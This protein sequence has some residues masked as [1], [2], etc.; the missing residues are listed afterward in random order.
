MRKS[1]R[2]TLNSCQEKHSMSYKK[3]QFLIMCC[4]INSGLH[5]QNIII[6]EVMTY[7]TEILSP[8]T[9]N[10]G[11]WIEIFN[12]TDDTISLGGYY[13]SDELEEPDKWQFPEGI[14]ISSSE[15]KII[16]LNGDDSSSNNPDEI[17]ANFK[18]NSSGESVYIFSNALTL[19]DESPDWSIQQDLTIG[20]INGSLDWQYMDLPSPGAENLEDNAFPF[21]AKFPTIT[22]ESGLYDASFLWDFI[23]DNSADVIHYTLDF[24]DPD[25]SSPILDNSFLINENVTIKLKVYRENALA[26]P[27][28]IN[29]YIIDTSLDLDIISITADPNDLFGVEG[30]YEN[31]NSGIEKEVSVQ[32]FIAGENVINQNMGVKI[33]APDGRSQKSLRLYARSE[34]GNKTVEYQLFDDKDISSFKR[35]VLR[36]GGNDGA[37]IGE[38]YVRD[39]LGHNLY[40]ESDESNG[41]SSS[42]AVDVFINGEY[43]GIYNLRERQDEY[44]LK[45]NYGYDKDEVDFLEYDYAEPFHMKTIS[46]NWINWD[47]LKEFVTAEDLSVQSNYEIAENWIDID[48][49][50]D[51]QIFQI[52]IGNPDWCNNNIKFWRATNNGRWRWVMWDVEYGF[53]TFDYQPVGEPEFNFLHMAISWCGWGSSDYS[54]LFRNL[55]ENEDFKNKFITR[56]QDVLNTSFRFQNVSAKINNLTSVIEPDLDRQFN[57]WGS[58][59]NSW[60]NSLDDLYYYTEERP[61]HLLNNMSSTFDI[62][63]E[64][65]VLSIDISD[66]QAGEIKLNTIIL[67]EETVGSLNNTFPWEG[68]YYEEQL[69]QLEAIEY[70][71]YDFSHWEG[72]L[73][74]ENPIIELYLEENIS[75]TAVYDENPVNNP[76]YSALVINELLSSN[77]NGYTD[78]NGEYEDW[79]ELYNNSSSE[80]VISGVYLSD[81]PSN[82]LKFQI[83][84]VKPEIQI[85]PY[86]HVIFFADNQIFQGDYH[87]N[88]KLNSGGEQLFVSYINSNNEVVIIDQ[89][90]FDELDSDTSFGR[91]IDADDSWITFDIPT[92][93]AENEMFTNI[94]EPSFENKNLTLYPNPADGFLN[95]IITGN[96]VDNLSQIEIYSIDGKLMNTISQFSSQ[97]RI[98]VSNLNSGIYIVQF[99]DKNHE[100]IFSKKFIKR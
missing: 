38:S 47:L 43:W 46:G 28:L 93:D 1:I 60:Q 70:A 54:W 74:S 78:S 20:R 79:I 77:E 92:P 91:S 99:Y 84:L 19:I 100:F 59:F 7:N 56:T 75:L 32:M 97:N 25:D 45:S 6:N 22:A 4:A 81:N 12:P 69:I 35:L 14:T 39:I 62:P 82:L 37:E 36:N 64:R 33:H 88:F 61:T 18:L 16:W 40:L 73:F 23:K 2:S 31:F 10:S 24:T 3:L 94:K 90:S 34:Y 13:L 42:R 80:L 86:D 87:T 50:I 67:N 55:L 51:Y 30:I 15:Y 41:M 44:Y 66:E 65:N 57:R 83:P 76:D 52:V 89:I 5:A 27:I 8:I 9:N 95:F 85:A 68:N 11:D 48:N 58:S 98:D 49:F 21:E 26:S 17:T 53:G 71:N 96:V 63:V 72:D 29:T